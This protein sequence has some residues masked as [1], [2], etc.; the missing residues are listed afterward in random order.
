LKGEK[1]MG[2]KKLANDLFPMMNDWGWSKKE[3]KEQWKEFKDNMDTL[4]DQYQDMQKSAK[5]A[6]KEQWET[7][8]SQFMDMQQTVADAIPE[9]APT[10]PGMPAPKEFVEKMKDFQETANEHAVQQAD[11]MFD[12][13]VERQQKAK[14][15]VPH[16]KVL[17]AYYD[18]LAEVQQSEERM[19]ELLVKGG[20][21]SE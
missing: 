2:K 12:F 15:V 18:A 17:K 14:E 21:V 19:R 9:D 4:W 13:M 20:Y 3:R 11:N 7:F 10:L 16:D 8:F 6:W 1:E 5:K